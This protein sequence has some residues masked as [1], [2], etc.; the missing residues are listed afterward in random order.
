MKLPRNK[1]FIILVIGF[2]LWIG[3]TAYFGFNKEPESN[4]EAFL[5]FVSGA[6]MIYGLIGDLL[7]NVRITKNYHNVNTT[8]IKTKNVEV[9]GEIQR[10]AYHSHYKVASDPKAKAPAKLPGAPYNEK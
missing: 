9:S 2:I 7:R 8:N 5:D 10:V 1:Y 4:L 6:M 3:E